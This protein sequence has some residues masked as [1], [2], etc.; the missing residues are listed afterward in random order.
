MYCSRRLSKDWGTHASRVL[1]IPSRHRELLEKGHH[2][3][4]EIYSKA[5]SGE[6][7]KPTRETRTLPGSAAPTKSK[8]FTKSINRR[9]AKHRVRHREL[10][11]KSLTKFV[12]ST[13][14]YRSRGCAVI[15]PAGFRS[16]PKAV[17][18][19]LAKARA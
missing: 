15:Q 4:I 6:T 5:C 1:A 14:N 3:R 2:E 8:P 7:P 13:R 10:I 12:V 9:S 17:V 11:S 16:T 19:K 18:A